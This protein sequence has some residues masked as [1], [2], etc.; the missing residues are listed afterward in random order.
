MTKL[1]KKTKMILYPILFVLPA[2]FNSEIYISLY[3]DIILAILGVYI[4]VFY[5]NIKDKEKNNKYIQ[6]D[7][8]LA[9]IFLS[10]V[11]STGTAII[12][13]CL[14][15]ML[16]DIILL[17]NKI[18]GIKT[19]LIT[20]VSLLIGK[21]TWNYYINKTNSTV[22]WETSKVNISNI[23][24][25]LNGKGEKYQYIT[26]NKFLKAI[27]KEKIGIF[28]YIIFFILIIS[29]LMIKYI[30]NKEKE[31]IK[32][33][34]FNL[35]VLIIYP[36]SLLLM[37]IFIFNSVEAENLASYSR[38]MSTIVV[39]ISIINLILLNSDKFVLKY[40]NII[41]L[42]FIGLFFINTATRKLI[43]RKSKD[44]KVTNEIRNELIKTPEIIKNKNNKIYFISGDEGYY[45]WM[46]RYEVTP[47]K[48]QDWYY[49]DKV[50]LFEELKNY[51]YLY[52][53]NY[54]EGFEEKYAKLFEEKIEKNTF[55]VI[56]KENKEIQ[57]KKLN[58]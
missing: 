43:I 49:S 22:V 37:Y 18:I 46:Y 45:Y 33:L 24:N 30:K 19:I 5:E 26:S 39:F 29:I 35:L 57:L 47:L 50:N 3:V 41:Y 38:Y 23:I 8:F 2:V 54:E 27:L 31:N 20:L 13:F 48:I 44:I 9:V 1:E 28:P 7:M 10:L 21:N 56:V 25:V 4:I 51:D 15:Y 40:K 53:K 36:I 58:K 11:K 17:K 32:L 6:L 55:Y 12:V 34:I 52:I 16:L 14:I 42:L